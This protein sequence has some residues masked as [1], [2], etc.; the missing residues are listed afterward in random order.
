MAGPQLAHHMRYAELNLDRAPYKMLFMRGD[1]VAKTGFAVCVATVGNEPTEAVFCKGA[2]MLVV[3]GAA[4][5]QI[6][7]NEGVGYGTAPT[8]VVRTT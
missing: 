6:K 5:A 4:D 8:W 1:S 7:L 2:L 3:G